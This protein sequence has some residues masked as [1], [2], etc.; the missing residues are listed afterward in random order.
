MSPHSVFRLRNT[1]LAY[2]ALALAVVV[3]LIWIDEI[4]DV[5]T[6]CWAP[7]PP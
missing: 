4:L 2:E 3:S 5:P 1:A 7:R 6:I